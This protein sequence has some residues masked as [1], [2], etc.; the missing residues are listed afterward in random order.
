MS[1]SKHE[2]T[3]P[4]YLATRHMALDDV[5]IIVSKNI[6]LNGN[7]QCGLHASKVLRRYQGHFMTPVFYLLCRPGV[8]LKPL[9]KRYPCVKARL[10]KLVYWSQ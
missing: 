8:L 5:Q 2:R 9:H 1:Q 6:I 4:E 7:C 10:H 3:Q